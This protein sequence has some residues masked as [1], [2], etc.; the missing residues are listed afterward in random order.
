LSLL[1]AILDNKISGHDPESYM[2]SFNICGA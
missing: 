2:R 1:D